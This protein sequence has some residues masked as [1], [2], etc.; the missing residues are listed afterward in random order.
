MLVPVGEFPED[1]GADACDAEGEPKEQA[2]HGTHPP[3]TGSFAYTMIAE[4]A[5]ARISPMTIESTRVQNR[6]T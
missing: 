1:G 4:N 2:G 5:E 3:G 6:S